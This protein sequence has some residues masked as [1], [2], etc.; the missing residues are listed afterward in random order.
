MNYLHPDV[1]DNGPA[2]LRA[3]AG[4]V[5]VLPE[6]VAE[7][8]YAQTLASALIS[9]PI[10]AEYFALLDDGADRRLTFMGVP[11][12]ATKSV[13]AGLPLHLVFTDGTSRVL[14]VASE[15]S[16]RAINAGQGY[17]LPAVSYL[18]PQPT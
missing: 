10:T 3:N 1:L 7:M 12:V 4:R 6:Y 17:R 18:S 16:H 5:L 14:W 9:V 8:T 15:A 11:G 2:Y 13:E